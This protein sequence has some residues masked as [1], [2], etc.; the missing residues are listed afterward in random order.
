MLRETQ[1]F[2]TYV[3]SHHRHNAIFS[4]ILEGYQTK[5][6]CCVAVF[7]DVNSKFEVKIFES[8]VKINNAKQIIPVQKDKILI[9]GIIQSNNLT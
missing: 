4:N 5:Q 7:Q 2:S 3:H 6:T 1:E 9:N 8:S